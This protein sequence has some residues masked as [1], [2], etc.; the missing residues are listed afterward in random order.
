MRS[1]AA[2]P[3]EACKTGFIAHII[4]IQQ[5]MSPFNLRNRVA[6]SPQ[7]RRVF[8]QQYTD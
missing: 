7:T 5:N 1:I 6:F 2:E 4:S 8:L 3:A